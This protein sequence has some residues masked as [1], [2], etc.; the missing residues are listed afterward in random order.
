MHILIIGNMGYVGSVVSRYMRNRFPDAHLSGFDSALFAHCLVSS[1]P[2]PEV[3]LNE[4]LFGDVRELTLST[5]HGVDAVIY[6]AAISNDPMGQQFANVTDEVN[7]K[8]CVK[9]AHL[10]EKAGVT[11]FV[12]ASS[13]SVYGAASEV[14]RTEQDDVSPLTAY[15]KSKIAAEKK[16]A[17]MQSDR[18]MISCLRFATACG[19]S[20]RLRL[21]LV[22]NDFVSAALR[23]GKVSVLSDGSPCRPLIDVK[24]MARIMEW[25]I[26]RSGAGFLIVNSGVDSGN[27]T[28][29]E[30]AFAV[31]DAIPGTQIDINYGALPDKRSYKVDFSLLAQLAPNYLPRISLSSTIEDLIAGI[32]NSG[33][34]RSD[35]GWSDLVRLQV[36]ANFIDAGIIDKE[37]RWIIR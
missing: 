19:F 28:V 27:Y 35:A 24:D 18:M 7:N 6:L 29:K 10:S 17:E 33:L 16:L 37:L 31:A 11:H 1:D 5:F 2:V 34:L 20:G 22:L 30:L 13:C 25:A 36:L 26:T 21:D 15:A 14:P 9:A 4:Q 23:T 3:V 8:C 12:L 32:S